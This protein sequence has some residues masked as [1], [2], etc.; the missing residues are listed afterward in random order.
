MIDERTLLGAIKYSTQ[1][2]CQQMAQTFAALAATPRDAAFRGEITR[3]LEALPPEREFELARELTEARAR[4]RA[5]NDRLWATGWHP[6]Q[7]R[8]ELEARG[9]KG[10]Q[11]PEGEAA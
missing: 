10:L 9:Y 11:V 1:E 8:R 7:M 2:E 6:E 4:I 5:H 3:R